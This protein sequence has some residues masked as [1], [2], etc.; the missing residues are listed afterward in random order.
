MNSQWKGAQILSLSVQ[1]KATGT[2]YSL[3]FCCCDELNTLMKSNFRKQGLIWITAPERE[4]HPSWWGRPGNR[5]PKP[6]SRRRRMADDIFIPHRKQRER[7]EVGQSFKPLK[8]APSD[9]PPPASLSLLQAQSPP[10]T[11]S[12]TEDKMFKPLSLW[13]HFSFRSPDTILHLRMLLPRRWKVWTV[14]WKN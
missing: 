9:R 6:G 11:A 3:H 14:G 13:G 4:S 1:T 2:L 5:Q 7:R 12:R 8:S 10:Q